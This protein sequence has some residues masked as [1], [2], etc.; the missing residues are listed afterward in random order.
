MVR[1]GFFALGHHELHKI[2]AWNTAPSTQEYPFEGAKEPVGLKGPGRCVWFECTWG[3]GSVKGCY[4]EGCFYEQSGEEEE[5]RFPDKFSAFVLA[6]PNHI[7]SR[8]KRVVSRR[9]LQPP[10]W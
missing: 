3:D 5:Y 7:N 10:E 8:L 4:P 6:Q 2:E 9:A 1:K